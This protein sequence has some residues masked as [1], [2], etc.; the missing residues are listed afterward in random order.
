IASYVR[1][2][3]AGN[4]MMVTHNVNIA[5]LSKHSVATGEM[6]LMRHAATEPGLGDPEGFRLDDC[7][8]QRNLSDEGRAHA[9]R[10]GERFRAERVPIAQVYT[11]PWCRCRETAIFAFGRA[12]DWTPLSSVFDFP[13]QE[14]DFTERVKKRIASYVRRNLAGNVMMVTHNVNIAALSKHSVATGE[15]VLM[16]PDGCC[17]ARPLERLAI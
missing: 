7:R 9:R 11:S 3:L 8:T 13:H 12:E 6:V 2:N 15:M 5:A 14:P 16:R 17:D 10:I 4:V 1:R